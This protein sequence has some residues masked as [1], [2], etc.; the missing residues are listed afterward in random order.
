VSDAPICYHVADVRPDEIVEVSK[1]PRCENPKACGMREHVY[2]ADPTMKVA[3]GK[4]R[5]LWMRDD[6]LRSLVDH[7]PRT[8]FARNAA[9]FTEANRADFVRNL[10]WH[11]EHLARAADLFERG[12]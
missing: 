5:G 7:Y 2:S 9:A 6:T 10:R 3:R 8:D 11:A 1:L 4:T 12:L